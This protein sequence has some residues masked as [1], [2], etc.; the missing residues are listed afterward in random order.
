MK[1]FKYLSYVFIALAILLSNVMCATIAYN[2]C[3]MLWGIKYAG[4]SAPA[5]VALLFI[6]PYAIGILVCGI[7]S[8][9]FSK[10]YHQYK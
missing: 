2:Y 5:S 4:F 8:C 3:D 1:K 7:L 6:I 10:K 9:L